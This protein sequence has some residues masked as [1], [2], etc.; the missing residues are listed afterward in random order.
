MLSLT[1]VN[2]LQP[3]GQGFFDEQHQGAEG[4]LTR[5]HQQKNVSYIFHHFPGILAATNL[6]IMLCNNVLAFTR[7]STPTKLWADI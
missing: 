6:W 1:K 4:Q 5:Q 2:F 3:L 7:N